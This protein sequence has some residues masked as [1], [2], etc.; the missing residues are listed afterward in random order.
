MIPDP[1]PKLVAGLLRR[2]PPSPG[3]SLVLVLTAFV[4]LTLLFLLVSFSSSVFSVC[5]SG[6]GIRPPHIPAFMPPLPPSSSRVA[7][8]GSGRSLAEVSKETGGFFRC[9]IVVFLFCFS[10][11]F[12]SFA[13]T[14]TSQGIRV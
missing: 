4:L 9:C 5:F 14:E 13:F 3:G 2:G 1:Q 6:Q 8:G 12:V 11:R 10:F 7:S